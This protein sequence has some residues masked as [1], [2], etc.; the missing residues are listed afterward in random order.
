MPFD[1]KCITASLRRCWVVLL[2]IPLP[3]IIFLTAG[4]SGRVVWCCIYSFMASFLFLWRRLNL[5]SSLSSGGPE[6]PYQMVSGSSLFLLL[7][8]QDVLFFL[9][10]R[11]LCRFT[12]QL[13]A[14]PE[15]AKCATH[16]AERLA[17]RAKE[18]PFH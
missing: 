11:L 1:S 18:R 9:Y 14:K 16:F 6:T 7:L 17:F 12:P 10:S 3:T 5:G 13:P 4:I 15:A 2:F 8:P